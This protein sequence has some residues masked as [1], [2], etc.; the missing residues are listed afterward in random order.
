MTGASRSRRIWLATFLTMLI[1]CLLTTTRSHAAG[2]ATIGDCEDRYLPERLGPGKDVV[3]MPTADDLVEA[4]LRLARVSSGDFVI[5]LGAGDGRIPIAAAR[6]FGA[7]AL[8]I[9]YN[10]DLVLLARCIVEVEGVEEQVTIVEGDI[11][12]EDFSAATVLTLFLLPELNLCIRHRVL[13]MQPGT[14]VVS[15]NFHMEEWLDDDRVTVGTRVGYLW[16]VPA[17][18]GGRWRF[19]DVDGNLVLSVNLQQ[20][21]Q[22]V[23]GEAHEGSDDAAGA[24]APLYDAVLRGEAIRFHFTDRAGRDATL[25]GYVHDGLIGATIRRAGAPAQPVTGTLWEEFAPAAWAEMVPGCE[26]FYVR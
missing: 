18:V 25:R 24:T 26:P 2:P 21:F 9:E 7:N 11:F 1:L 23:S 10:T 5:D 22:A 4:M 17:R 8:G 3:W 14:R 19:H 13:A 20:R 12:V 15:N 16:I 6:D